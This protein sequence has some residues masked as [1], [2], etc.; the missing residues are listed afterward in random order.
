VTVS[1]NPTRRQHMKR[2]KAVGQSVVMLKA[3]AF[4]AA[5]L[6]APAAAEAAGLSRATS[7][8]T[9]ITS[10]V[11]VLIPIIAVLALITL[12]ILWGTRVIRFVTLCQFGGAL[13]LAGSAAEIVS[14]LFS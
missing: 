2:E 14:M 5:I 13:I 4:V 11:R 3:A 6:V 7:V 8:L 9:S 10:D 1:F 12:A